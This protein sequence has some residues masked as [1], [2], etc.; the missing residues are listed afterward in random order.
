MQDQVT[1]ETMGKVGRRLLPFLFLLFAINFLD[2]V[3]VGFAAL[4]MNQVFGFG[5]EVYGFGAGIFFLGYTLLEV[6][7]NLALQRFGARV[8]LSRITISWGVVAMAAALIQGRTSFYLL[9]L[10]LGVAEAGL[11][12]GLI[13]YVS[14]WF[15]VE[16]RARAIA[17]V[18]LATAAAVVLGGPLSAAIM[19]L[20]GTFR[21][22]GWQWI[23]VLEGLPAVL[24]G[25]ASLR[26]LDD[27]PA[28]AAWLTPAERA[29]LAATLRRESRRAADH[30]AS[31]LAESLRSPAL[32]A[33][34]ALYFFIG[35]GFFGLTLWLPQIVKQLS[36]LTNV[37]VSLVTAIP[38]VLAAGAMLL[39]AWHSDLSGERRWHMALP[40]AVSA[41][42]LGGSGLAATPVMAF[43]LLCVAA[44]G[45]WSA[46]GVFW[47]VPGTFLTGTAAAAGLALINAVGGISGFIGPYAIGVLRGLSASFT[48]SLL[49]MAGCLFVAAV[50][51]AVIRQANREATTLLIALPGEAP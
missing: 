30:G 50:L 10:L 43:V 25:L 32:W 37:E 21:L 19:L 38:F 35:F 22:A 3:N 41:V 28:Q 48:T 27:I 18:W 33:L 51:S 45:L 13:Y 31:G 23:F 34:C 12:P 46:I 15:P 49:G 40:L 14:I 36:G 6:P 9:R 39:N 4:Q 42:G 7:S 20:D 11:V 5:P 47:S 26:Y 44:M 8:W 29:S 16:Q 2:R 17:R 24:L 1:D